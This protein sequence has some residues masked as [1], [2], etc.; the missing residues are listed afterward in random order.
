MPRYPDA[1]G[2]QIFMARRAPCL[3]RAKL[4]RTSQGALGLTK[5]PA[6]PSPQSKPGDIRLRAG[7]ILL[8][9]TGGAFASQ[10]RQGKHFSII[11]EMENTNPVSRWS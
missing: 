5:T 6:P 9:D 1:R 7:D 4:I 2:R 8:L 3:C 11:I 10:H